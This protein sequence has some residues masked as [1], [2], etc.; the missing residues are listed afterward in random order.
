VD[1]YIYMDSVG[2]ASDTWADTRMPE[3]FLSSRRVI[4]LLLFVFVFVQ[5]QRRSSLVDLEAYRRSFLSVVVLYAWRL[6]F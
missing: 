2:E 5:A 3:V 4:P 6:F 1:V